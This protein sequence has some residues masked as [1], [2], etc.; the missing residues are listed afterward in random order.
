MSTEE[1]LSS[2]KIRLAKGFAGAEQ[3]REG[4]VCKIR[5]GQN[6]RA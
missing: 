2:D 4:G 5:G 3:E 6:V 1:Q